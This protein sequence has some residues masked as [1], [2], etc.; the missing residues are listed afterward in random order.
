NLPTLGKAS[1]QAKQSAPPTPAA[2][3]AAQK[4]SPPAESGS[5]QSF[6]QNLSVGKLSI[7]DGVVSIGDASKPAKPRVYKNVNVTVKTFAFTSQ[8]PFTPSA[9]LARDG[10]LN[11]DATGA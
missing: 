6:Q 5:D 3:A 8:L 9:D 1:P 7:K 11:L 2:P 10:T 4:S